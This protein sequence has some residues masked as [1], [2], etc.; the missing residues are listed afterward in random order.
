M[1]NSITGHCQATCQDYTLLIASRVK[2]MPHTD[3]FM[4]GAIYGFIKSISEDGK[5]VVQLDSLR[6]PVKGYSVDD[7]R[8]VDFK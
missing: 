4:R 6:R 5:I 2:L 3:N 8:P 7:M 1:K